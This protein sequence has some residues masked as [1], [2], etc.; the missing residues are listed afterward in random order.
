MTTITQEALRDLMLTPLTEKLNWVRLQRGYLVAQLSRLESLSKSDDVPVSHV[1][2]ADI[3]VGAVQGLLPQTAFSEV[4]DA[5]RAHQRRARQRTAGA[6]D[7]ELEVLLEQRDVIL[8][9]VHALEDDLERELAQA[10]SITML[11]Q[12][13]F[14]ARP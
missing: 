12:R 4:H 9:Y 1:F 14:E 10:A 2:D 8:S 13:P 5:V 11:G 3:L 7:E 6:P